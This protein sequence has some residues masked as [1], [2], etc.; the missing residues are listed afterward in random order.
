M[1]LIFFWR[2]L[3][4]A[5][6][7]GTGLSCTSIISSPAEHLGLTWSL[8]RAPQPGLRGRKGR[9]GAGAPPALV[10]PA[11]ARDEEKAA[12]GKGALVFLCPR[13]EAEG[14]W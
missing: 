1:L 12:A 6:Q 7:G 13:A 14:K 3:L 4:S 10:L 9:G 11:L 5:A 2:S 8:P